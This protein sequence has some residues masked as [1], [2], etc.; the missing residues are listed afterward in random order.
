MD[1][2]GFPPRLD[3]FKGMAAHLAQKRADEED[4]PSLAILGQNWLRG[5]LNRHL[6]LSTRFSINFDKQ[7]S[8]ASNSKLIKPYFTKLESLLC[9][10]KFKPHNMYNMDEKGFLLGVSHRA[11]VIVRRGWQNAEETTD[12]SRDWITAVETCST[13]AMLSQM[14]IYKGKSL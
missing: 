14:I 13:T 10:Y 9:K 7:R 3:L 2:S 6:E 11:K 12:G 1:A 4:D 8:L 5:F